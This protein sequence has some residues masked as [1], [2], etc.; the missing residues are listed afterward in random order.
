MRSAGF[1]YS[2]GLTEASQAV[3]LWS[4]MRIFTWKQRGIVWT[5]IIA[6]LLLF[7]GIGR[8]LDA[9]SKTYPLFFIIFLL[10]SAPFAMWLTVRRLKPIIEDDLTKI[11]HD[12][13]A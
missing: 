8:L 1:S 9:A 7:G 6:S 3:I 12:M 11:Q 2:S 5:S 10:A 13:N 4:H